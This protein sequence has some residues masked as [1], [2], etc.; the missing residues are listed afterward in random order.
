MLGPARVKNQSG[1]LG[2][3]IQ[4]SALRPA[5]SRKYTGS[6]KGRGKPWGKPA[7]CPEYREIQALPVIQ[8]LPDFP[9]LPENANGSKAKKA[10]TRQVLEQSIRNGAYLLA[11]RSE[12]A[13]FRVDL[14]APTSRVDHIAG[15]V[16]QANATLGSH[17]RRLNTLAQDL[18]ALRNETT[19]LRRGVGALQE[20]IG[21][22][23]T[24][25]ERVVDDVAAIRAA[26]APRDPPE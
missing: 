22:I 11:L 5:L 17:G 4:I 20:D 25:L 3:P 14:H 16:V 1:G 9:V 24:K 15:D 6:K 8:A 7:T 19:A 21:R 18:T 23:D 12:V 2:V 26:V 10:V 13:S